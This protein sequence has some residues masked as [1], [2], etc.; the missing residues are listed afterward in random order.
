MIAGELHQNFTKSDIAK[1]CDFEHTIKGIKFN[2]YNSN[3]KYWSLERES[4]VEGVVQRPSLFGYHPGVDEDEYNACL[5][6]FN[7]HLLDEFKSDWRKITPGVKSNSEV[8]SRDYHYILDET[9]Y[10]E[11]NGTNY[12]FHTFDGI[13][14]KRSTTLKAIYD[15]FNYPPSTPSD[16]IDQIFQTSS[17]KVRYINATKTNIDGNLVGMF[18]AD[19]TCNLFVLT[20]TP[21]SG[22]T[23]EQRNV[24]WCTFDAQ[25]P[26]MDAI[27]GYRVSS[28]TGD[29]VF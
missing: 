4:T 11:Y 27:V 28:D 21:A 3:K 13:N 26:T 2:N 5:T 7:N 16:I 17:N 15:I 10:I 23:P 18:V 9:N 24:R 29:Y 12:Y 19:T 22:T 6:N 20:V 14:Y 1:L 25:K 8:N